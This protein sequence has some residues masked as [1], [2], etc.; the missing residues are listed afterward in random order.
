MLHEKSHD[1]PAQ[2]ATALAG[3]THVAHVPP[4]KSEPALHVKLQLLP[5][6]VATPLGLVAHGVQLEPHEATSPLETH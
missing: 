1:V 3:V 2:L 5:L 4:H 6:Q